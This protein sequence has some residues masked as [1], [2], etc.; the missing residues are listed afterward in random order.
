MNVISFVADGVGYKVSI[1][2]WQRVALVET[3]AIPP[4]VMGDGERTLM[5]ALARNIAPAFGGNRL[6]IR[7]LEEFHWVPAENPDGY[8]RVLRIEVGG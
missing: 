7:W 3:L 1:F 5:G 8:T 2:V 6:R 4:Q